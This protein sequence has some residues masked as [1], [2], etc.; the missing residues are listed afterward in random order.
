M[1]LCDSTKSDKKLLPVY[2]S[3]KPTREIKAELPIFDKKKKT[4]TY[5]YSTTNEDAKVW[6]IE[7]N[8]TG[9]PVSERS[10]LS[11]FYSKTSRQDSI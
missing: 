8:R 10:S 5:S 7:L 11:E 4:S 3:V 1:K 6:M 9:I 2:A